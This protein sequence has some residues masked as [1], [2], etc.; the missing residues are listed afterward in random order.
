MENI[1]KKDVDFIIFSLNQTWNNAH[2]KL[3][4]N[5]LGDLERKMFEQEKEKAKELMTKLGA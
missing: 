1:T 2:E 3:S 4:G 5:S